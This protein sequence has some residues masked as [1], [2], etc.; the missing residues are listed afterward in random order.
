[1]PRQRDEAKVAEARR[2]YGLGLTTYAIAAQVHADPRTVQ[3]WLGDLIRPAGPR[4]RA[5]VRADAVL[6]LRDREGLN[7]AEIGRRVGMS[8]T[9]ARM[10]YYALI[11]RERPERAKLH[12]RPEG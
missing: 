2:L 4:K 6:D 5:D 8:R 1:M 10:R 9:G 7:W 11:G 12:E 3:R